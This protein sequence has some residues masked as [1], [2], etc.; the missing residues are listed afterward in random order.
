MSR[1]DGGGEEFLVLLPDTSLL[2]ALTLAE[3]LRSQVA[4]HPFRFQDQALPVTISAGVCSIAKARS[5]NDLLKQADL[6]LY[7]A[8]EAGRNQ[9]APRVRS[10]E[11]GTSASLSS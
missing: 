6:N 11:S 10:Q 5:L 9:I 3:R 1:P 4:H 8:K 2:Q 7:N